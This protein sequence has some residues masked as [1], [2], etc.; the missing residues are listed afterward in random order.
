MLCDGG[1]ADQ[2]RY[3]GNNLSS[4]NFSDYVC[5]SVACFDLR[6]PIL[7]CIYVKFLW[8][9]IRCLGGQYYLYAS[10]IFKNPDVACCVRMGVQAV[11][12]R[13][14]QPRVSCQVTQV[15]PRNVCTRTR[16]CSL[17]WPALREIWVRVFNGA[18]SRSKYMLE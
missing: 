17:K 11:I 10:E 8:M 6:A 9:L 7:E 15:P 18:L 14:T 12:I 1:G 4:L 16:K 5:V 13:H 2:D 3:Q